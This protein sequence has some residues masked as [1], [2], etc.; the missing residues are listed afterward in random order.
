MTR[1]EF[2]PASVPAVRRGDALDVAELPSYGFAHRSL[3]WWGNAGMMAIEGVAFGFMI[4]IYFYLR[5]LSNAWP[6]G[7]TRRTCCWGTINLA[8]IL[9]SAMPNW[10][11][12]KAAADRDFAASACGSIVLLRLRRRA[13]RRALVRV[14]RAQRA[15]GRRRLWSTVW[16]LLGLHT[17]NL[18]TDVA[19][20]FVL[21]A[22]MLRQAARRQAL[23][24]HRRKLRLLV[25]RRADVA[26]DLRGDLLR[27]AVLDMRIWVALIVAPLLALTDQTVA[28]ALVHWA[29]AHQSTWVVHLSHVVF[30]AIAAAAAV[31]AWLR[32]RETAISAG[33]GRS[34]GPVSFP[35]RCRD[36]GR[37]VV[38]ALRSWR[39]GF[40]P[41]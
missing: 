39:C 22:V 27:R 7:G 14:H 23:R 6:D 41:G 32:W 16:V 4:V 29:C 13:V 38:R 5:S 3:M 36:D 35:R 2:V 15:L 19:D 21:T 25:F 34:D 12:D 37:R 1:R 28:F 10:L 31:G 9:A 33:S 20:T 11:A 8:I 18:V 40:R 17:F 30:L 24:R 26:A